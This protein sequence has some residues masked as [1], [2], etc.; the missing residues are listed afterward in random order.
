MICGMRTT[1]SAFD[2]YRSCV[3]DAGRAPCVRALALESIVW[4]VGFAILLAIARLTWCAVANP[5]PLP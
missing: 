1:P 2:P 5:W 4:I 3:V